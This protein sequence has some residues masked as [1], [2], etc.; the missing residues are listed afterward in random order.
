MK[1]AVE[2]RRKESLDCLPVP[3]PI[4]TAIFTGGGDTCIL[5]ELKLQ[6]QAAI[7]F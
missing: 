2:K 4:A 7:S 1:S 6:L 5:S 3:T